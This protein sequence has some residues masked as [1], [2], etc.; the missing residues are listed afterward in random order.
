MRTMER[1]VLALV[2]MSIASTGWTGRDKDDTSIQLAVELSDGSRLIGIPAVIAVSV[3]TSVGKIA[4]PLA[5][6]ATMTFNDDHESIIIALANGDRLTGVQDLGELRLK[7]L[8]GSVTINAVLI[9]K[10][11]CL[12]G[13]RDGGLVLHYT[14]DDDNFPRSK[15]AHLSLLWI[16]KRN[17]VDYH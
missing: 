2:M 1:V 12:G 6:V 14:F 17:M 16:K 8:F 7:C 11:D 15:K 9:R 4:V 3:V 5:Q 13:S 10:I